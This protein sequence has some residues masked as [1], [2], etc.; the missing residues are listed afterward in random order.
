MNVLGSHCLWPE[1]TFWAKSLCK[2]KHL[3]RVW[4]TNI[5]SKQTFLY[6]LNMTMGSFYAIYSY[7]LWPCRYANTAYGLFT[8]CAFEDKISKLADSHLVPLQ[9]YN[10]FFLTFYFSCFTVFLCPMILWYWYWKINVNTKVCV[11]APYVQPFCSPNLTLVGY[12]LSWE[13]VEISLKDMYLVL[14]WV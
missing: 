8:M 4:N 11:Y 9:K 13:K 1:H 6:W 10:S 2:V 5:I 3:Q 7:S 14:T 12:D